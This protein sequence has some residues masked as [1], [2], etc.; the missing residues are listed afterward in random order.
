MILEYYKLY[1]AV[2]AKMA[3]GI[4][5]G[6]ATMAIIFVICCLIRKHYLRMRREF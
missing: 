1:F 5:L 4:F 2:L 3:Y 6:V